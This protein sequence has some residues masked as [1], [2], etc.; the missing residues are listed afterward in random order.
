M[1]ALLKGLAPQIRRLIHR[2]HE[3]IVTKQASK[4]NNAGMGVYTTCSVMKGEV[5]RAPVRF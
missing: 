2:D 3:P 4:I 1:K 5:C